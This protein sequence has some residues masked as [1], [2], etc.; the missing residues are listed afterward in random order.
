MFHYN[1]A[2]PNLS[3]YSASIRM[4]ILRFIA[5]SSPILYHLIPFHVTLTLAKVNLCY[6]MKSL[7]RLNLR[8]IGQF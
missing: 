6:L 1:H 4:S 5:I 7:S 8:I 2:E 3:D